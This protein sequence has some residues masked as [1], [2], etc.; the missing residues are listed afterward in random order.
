MYLGHGT[1]LS[2]H[3][4]ITKMYETIRWNFYWPNMYGDI[5]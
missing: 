1:V 5:E 3:P 4:G 2:G